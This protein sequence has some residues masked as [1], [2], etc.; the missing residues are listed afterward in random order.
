MLSR[1]PRPG[2]AASASR[3]DRSSS[4][5]PS[6]LKKAARRQLTRVAGHDQLRSPGERAEGVDRLD[7]ARLVEHQQIEAQRPRRQELGDRRGAHHEH[8]LDRLDRLRGA[9]EQLPDRQVAA[10]LGELALEQAELA[11]LIAALRQA[12]VMSRRNLAP[13]DPDPLAIELLEALDQ[14]LLLRAGE[15]RK[16]RIGGD[17]LTQQ[18]LIVGL[19]EGVQRALGGQP[20]MVQ[21][22]GE[23]AHAKADRQTPL[24]TVADPEIERRRL[25]RPAGEALQ[26]PGQRHGL[27]LRLAECL[28][29]IEL[30]PLRQRRPAG[31]D[32]SQETPAV[33]R[34]H[35][36]WLAVADL[37]QQTQQARQQGRLRQLAAP[38]EHRAELVPV[39]P[40]ARPEAAERRLSES[41]ALDDLVAGGLGPD[42]AAEQRQL[43][44]EPR[45]RRA[46]GDP[47]E[48]GPG[49]AP[50]SVAPA[51]P[52]PA[53]RGEVP[54]RRREIERPGGFG[55][56]PAKLVARGR[57]GAARRHQITDRRAVVL[58]DL[59]LQGRR[60]GLG[61]Q[62]GQAGRA[63]DEAR[64]L[65]DGGVRRPGAEPLLQLASRLEQRRELLVQRAD[66]LTDRLIIARQH[67]LDADAAPGA[68]R[69]GAE[70][71][72]PPDQRVQVVAAL[73]QLGAAPMAGARELDRAGH[74][75]PA[76]QL[77]QPADRLERGDRGAADG[78]V[79][80]LGM[81]IEARARRRELPGAR[82]RI[83]LAGRAE[84]QGP[85]ELLEQ[86]ALA[87]PA[88]V[89]LLAELA[90]PD[91]LEPAL[92]RLERGHL[93]GD[94]QHGLAGVH[95]CG[96]QVR[97]GLR[98][99]AAGRPLDQKIVAGAGR[100]ERERLRGVG[101]E[102]VQR[103]ARR[104]QVIE[105][106]AVEASPGPR[107]SLRS[108][109]RAAAGA[110]RAPSRPARS[111]DRDR[112]RSGARRRR[113]GRGRC[114]R[115]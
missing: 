104:Q 25:R 3:S 97:D 73:A 57:E 103:G 65:L 12:G 98:L 68:E 85:L 100:L 101:V 69:R 96:D 48:H 8:R 1:S 7:L 62:P 27:D 70:L 108:A 35:D 23:P 106:A 92:D 49:A 37:G 55:D 60:I 86:V 46:L 47:A 41:L 114:G 77:G 36:R 26:H 80:A 63:V 42:Q 90:E 107:E 22:V 44:T 94:E 84:L 61:G 5:P 89:Q 76:A 20:A 24:R 4:S 45:R 31:L 38:G 81:A 66:R 113:T 64:Q 13:R 93:L 112:G 29:R 115:D 18:R 14:Q 2:A 53:M 51:P 79:Q 78:P 30:E 105:P 28:A 33:R 59:A 109:A 34:E 40:L 110:G 43:V 67:R 32:R 6:A 11:D 102:H 15:G 16:H 91:L 10:L 82:A 39:G 9:R 54:T 111:P 56:H 88:A 75:P 52:G 87:G 74:G 71:A 99:A 95:R 17:R 19:V 58:P 72:D 21:L 50:G 83:G